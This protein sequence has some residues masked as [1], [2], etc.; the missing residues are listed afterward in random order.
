MFAR[1]VALERE[2]DGAL[3]GE[4]LQGPPSP[5]LMRAA[6]LW[7]DAVW[8]AAHAAGA[9]TL[10]N[11]EIAAGLAVASRPVFVCGAHRSGTTLVRDLV[12]GHPALIVLPSEG[13]FF[14]NLQSHLES[15]A[16]NAHLPLV[17]G[18][19]LRRLAN[20]INRPPYW[21]LGRTTDHASPYI[22]YAQAL[23]A[24]WT[25][26]EARLGPEIA[27]WPLVAVALAYASCTNRF[28]TESGLQRWV[29]KTPTNE[30]FVGRL[31]R[32]FPAAM[33]VHV[34]RHPFA[35]FASRKRLEIEATTRGAEGPFRSSRRVLRELARSYRVAIEHDTGDPSV[36]NYC[37][38]RYEALV[39]N[40]P[41]VVEKLARAIGIEPLPILLRPTVNGLP[42]SANSSIPTGDRRGEILPN[43]NDASSLTEAERDLVTAA[44]GELAARLGYQLPALGRWRGRALL[45]S[46]WMGK[47]DR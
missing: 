33:F 22:A 28:D 8:A 25:V 41:Q 35:V 45:S 5:A 11:R 46:R 14:T 7:S 20:P 31:R 42:A 15:H 36:T 6:R 26:T 16:P 37:V 40:R 13:T 34:V 29:E 12:D 30:Q 3:P 38:I 21:L 19:W 17:G 18:E 32:E 9:R 27:S 24:W 47:R 23:M 44:V 10:D 1:I 2:L 39:E 4:R 43:S